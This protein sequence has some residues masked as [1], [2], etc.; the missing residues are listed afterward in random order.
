METPENTGQVCKQYSN[1]YGVAK[2]PDPNEVYQKRYYVEK[3]VDDRNA[4]ITGVRYCNNA[5]GLL[6]KGF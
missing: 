2:Y 5:G 6:F 3:F 4:I 1:S